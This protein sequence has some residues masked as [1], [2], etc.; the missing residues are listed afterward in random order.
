MKFKEYLRKVYPVILPPLVLIAGILG[1]CFYFLGPVGKGIYDI[2][3]IGIIAIALAL[4][5]IIFILVDIIKNGKKK[6]VLN[7]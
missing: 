6:W 1:V 2:L 5:A 4:I 3:I 7:Y